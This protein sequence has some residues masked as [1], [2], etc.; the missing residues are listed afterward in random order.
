MHNCEII[1]DIAK[2]I[3]GIM[4]VRF[5][6]IFMHLRG[7]RNYTKVNHMFQNFQHVHVSCQG[8]RGN[9]K[10]PQTG[11]VRLAHENTHTSQLSVNYREKY[12]ENISQEHCQ[13]LQICSGLI[14][15]CE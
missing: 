12:V 2:C 11:F 13:R 8:R 7:W 6:V 4:T 5:S 10:W 1:N 3:R 15:P 14:P 9:E